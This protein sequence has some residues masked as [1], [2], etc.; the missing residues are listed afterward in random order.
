MK[1]LVVYYSRSGKT[2]F[3]AETVA[4]ELGADLEEIVDHKKRD[5]KIGWI[6]S[7]K[8][9]SQ[10]KL[11]EIELAK[12]ATCDYDLIVL[13]TPIWAWSPSPALRTY[14]SQN[15]LA[16]KKAAIFYTFDSDP[17]GAS[18]KIRE[19][20]PNVEIAA[21]LPLKDPSKNK[22]ETQKKI[23]EWCSTLKSLST[24]T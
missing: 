9:A 19:M 13:G 5:G 16:D 10:G 12:H 7:G 11:T 6:V 1:S 2:K 4:A 15:V 8:D 23:A 24:A 3:V 14:V 21:E 18:K 17:K 22:E 20:M